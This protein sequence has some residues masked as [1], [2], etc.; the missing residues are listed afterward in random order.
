MLIKY[1]FADGTVSEVEVD[2]DLG[3]VMEQM[4]LDE[5]NLDR[6]ETRRHKYMSELEEKGR[7]IVDT[8][9]PLEDILEAELHKELMAAIEK[10]APQQKELLIRVYWNNELQKDIAIEEGVSEMAISKRMKRILKK[11]NKFLR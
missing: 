2:D 3:K 10:L 8:S 1:T 4:A 7:Y 9:D 6:A 5:C 11:L